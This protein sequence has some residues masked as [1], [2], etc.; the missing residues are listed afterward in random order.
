M[1]S[2][3][4]RYQV[5]QKPSHGAQQFLDEYTVNKERNRI[6]QLSSFLSEPK[7]SSDIQTLN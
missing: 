4:Q 6:T 1:F 2:L 3:Q 7:H 5:L